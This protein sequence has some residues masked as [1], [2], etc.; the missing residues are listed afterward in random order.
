MKLNTSNKNKLK[1]KMFNLMD[2]VQLTLK[3]GVNIDDFL[4]ETDLFSAW[5]EMIP[6]KEYP[7]FIMAVLNN[8]RKESI[9]DTILDSLTLENQKK[10]QIHLSRKNELISHIGELPFN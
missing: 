10:N 9:I 8:I 7:I 4:D 1:I 2:E 3:E 5:E 6:E